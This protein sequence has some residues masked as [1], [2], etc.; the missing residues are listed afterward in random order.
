MSVEHGSRKR[1]SRPGS[2]TP[3]TTIKVKHKK[4]ES[5]HDL[6]SLVWQ[7][8]REPTLN[9]LGEHLPPLRIKVGSSSSPRKTYQCKLGFRFGKETVQ[10]LVAHSRN[11]MFI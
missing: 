1:P 9:E 11:V 8:S 10:K 5:L 7:A 3:H 2:V 4:T 6:R